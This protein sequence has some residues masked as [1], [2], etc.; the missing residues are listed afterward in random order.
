MRRVFEGPF[1]LIQLNAF[2]H[3]NP[4]IEV[5]NVVLE[6]EEKTRKTAS[7]DRE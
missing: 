2:R 6:Y 3:N 4:Y 1:P 7:D 5:V